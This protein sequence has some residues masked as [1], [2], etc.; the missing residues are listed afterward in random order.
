MQKPKSE[1]RA[2]GCNSRTTGWRPCR[3]ATNDPAAQADL[4]VEA[5][6]FRRAAFPLALSAGLPVTLLQP[7]EIR[8]QSLRFT[9]ART[10]RLLAI[11][12]RIHIEMAPRLRFGNEAL[13]IERRRDRTGV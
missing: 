11:V 4:E 6:L 7:S 13:E 12:P 2:R 8:A 1:E 5:R 9:T 3:Q 10:P